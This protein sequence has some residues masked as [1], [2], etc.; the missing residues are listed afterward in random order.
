MTVRVVN[1]DAEEF[2]SVTDD[3]TISVRYEVKDTIGN[4]TYLNI[5]VYISRNGKM[6]EEQVTYLRSLGETYLDT[7]SELGGLAKDSRWKLDEAYQG[8]LSD[9]YDDSSV[10]DLH[11]GKRHLQEIRD[12][13]EEQGFGNSLSSGEGL[14]GV[15]GILGE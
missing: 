7:T 2:K 10:Y 5:N 9:A 1:Y 8:A 3:T 12:Y 13:V 4:K 11:L 15:W 14:D 6:P